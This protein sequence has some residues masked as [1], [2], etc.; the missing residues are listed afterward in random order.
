[1]SAYDLKR[2][3]LNELRLNSYDNPVLSLGGGEGDETAGVH[4]SV[5]WC[6]GRM[7][8]CR[9]RATADS[10][11]NRLSQRPVQSCGCRTDG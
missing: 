9:A 2:T 6:G 4:Y 5:W 1:M 3:S 7:A 11:R 10:A 8:S